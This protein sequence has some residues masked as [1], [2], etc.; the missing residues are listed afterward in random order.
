MVDLMEQ[1]EKLSIDGGLPCS[2]DLF[3]TAY[4]GFQNYMRMRKSHLAVEGAHTSGNRGSWC[5]LF[6]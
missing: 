2:E 3:V 4:G 5:P 6:F 1:Q